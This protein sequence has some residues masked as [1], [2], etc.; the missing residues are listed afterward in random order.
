MTIHININDFFGCTLNGDM[1]VSFFNYK[2]FLMDVFSLHVYLVKVTLLF[3]AMITMFQK[4]GKLFM[5]ILHWEMVELYFTCDMCD[6]TF[7]YNWF[8]WMHIEW[9]HGC[10]F[11]QLNVYLVKVTLLF[12]AMITMFQ[13]DGK[14]WKYW[15]SFNSQYHMIIFHRHVKVTLLFD[16]MIT[17]LQEGGT[18]FFWKYLN[19]IDVI[20]GRHVFYMRYVWQY[21]GPGGFACATRGGVAMRSLAIV[22]IS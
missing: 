12:D 11:F 17:M 15:V 2:L 5:S 1:A 21:I 20:N 7:E 9:W 14:L 13:K 10:I 18:L 22:I 4:D 8:L 16:T 3:D 19:V 6:S